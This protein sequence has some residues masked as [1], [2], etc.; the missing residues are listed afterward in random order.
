[1]K[2]NFKSKLMIIVGIILSLIFFV[3]EEQMQDFA[4]NESSVIRV[5]DGDTIVVLTE[6]GTEETVRLLLVDTPEINKNQPYS[7]E[8]KRYVELLLQQQEHVVLEIG[9]ND[10][11]KYGRLL[12]YVWINDNFNLNE[13]LIQKGY[14][15]VAYVYEPNTK[16]I[17]EF[18]Q[19]ES[20]AK[21][22]KLNIWSIEGYVTNRGFRTD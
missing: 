10:R 9:E 2:R 16:Y 11:D 1:M 13:D 14:A 6:D 21:E 12:A 18:R 15:R 17:D 3:Y 5:I 19:A 20:Q 22:D 4:A 8:A 7:E